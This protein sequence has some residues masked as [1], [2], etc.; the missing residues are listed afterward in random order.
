MMIYTSKQK[1]NIYFF[2]FYLKINANTKK[3]E[4]LKNL[5]E[6]NSIITKFIK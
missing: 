1:L 3:I 2:I 4:A 6:F 5:L